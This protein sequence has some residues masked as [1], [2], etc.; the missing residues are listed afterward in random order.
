MTMINQLMPVPTKE[1]LRNVYHNCYSLEDYSVDLLFGS[2]FIQ[3]HPPS[4]EEDN[5][6]L[7]IK[8]P[9]TLDVEK[10]DLKKQYKCWFIKYNSHDWYSSDTYLKIVYVEEIPEEYKWIQDQFIRR[11]LPYKESKKV[12]MY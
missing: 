3:V 11:F 2:E 6:T 8:L 4:T 9:E 5:E 1:E 7:H 10:I 12:S